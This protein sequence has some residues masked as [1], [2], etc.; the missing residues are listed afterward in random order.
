MTISDNSFSS[1]SLPSSSNSASTSMT[2][3][4]NSF[5]ATAFS[6]GTLAW[7]GPNVVGGAYGQEDSFGGSGTTFG[8]DEYGGIA[9]SK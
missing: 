3:S 5:S 8:T 1:T 9:K 4:S 2:A 7:T 6:K